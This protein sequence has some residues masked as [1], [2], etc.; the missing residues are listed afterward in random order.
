M[1]TLH[2]NKSTPCADCGHNYGDHCESGM[3]HFDAQDHR[4]SCITAHCICGPCRCPAFVNP[5]TGA[6]AAWKRPTLPET[7]CAQ[8][9]HPKQH[10]CRKGSTGIVVDGVPHTCSHYLRYLRADFTG[11]MECTDTRCAEI[12]DAKQE[13]FCSC[14]RFKNPYLRPRKKRVPKTMTTLFSHEELQEMYDHAHAGQPPEPKTKAEIPVEVCR[15]FPDTNVRELSE[16]SGMSTSWVRKHLRAAG[17]VL[18]KSVRRKEV[19]P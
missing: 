11:P 16:A 8:C 19:K 9:G 3:P 7:P 5:H 4:Y 15:E 13:I 14:S 6:I 17:I 1:S 18:A 10:H 2:V 12:L